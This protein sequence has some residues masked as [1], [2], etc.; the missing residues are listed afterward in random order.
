MTDQPP[1]YR[2][3]TIIERDGQPPFWL[4][5]GSAFPHKDGKGFNVLLQALPLDGKLVLRLY[6]EQPDGAKMEVSPRTKRKVA[7]PPEHV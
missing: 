7:N 3:Y 4:N 6:E 1:P 5:L 2:A